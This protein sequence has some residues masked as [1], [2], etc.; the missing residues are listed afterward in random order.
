MVGKITM[1]PSAIIDQACALLAQ[2]QA[3]AIPTETVYG[4]AA[5][6]IQDRGVAA[7]YALKNRPIFNPLIIH[8][9]TLEA[10]AEVAVLTPQALDFAHHFWPG[11]LT[12]V[13]KRTAHSSISQLASGGLETVAIR[14]PAHPIMQTLMRAY[15]KP[16][17]APSANRS[18]HISPTTPDHVR[19]SFGDQTP[20]IVDGGPCV[21]GVE[22]TI[23]DMTGEVPT[24]LRPGFVTPEMIQE[25]LGV[26][27]INGL[28][29][30]LKAPGMMKRH[31][32]P[33]R[34]LRINALPSG[35][36]QEAYIGFGPTQMSCTFNLSFT[37]CLIEAA[38][39]LFSMLHQAD[40]PPFTS[41]AVAPIP[42]DGL[43]LAIND[44][45]Q[46]AAA[47]AL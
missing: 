22:S 17:A 34:P 10:A 45:L 40:R 35:D 44:R 13:L 29:G 31:Y 3:V 36:T 12:L 7:V 27:V 5:D 33:T 46:R 38:A 28:N 4:L 16:L 23:I 43:G 19:A 21:V 37:G 26:Q 8:V 6:A 41:I 20:F 2:G 32:A 11:P 24:L 25:I 1:V 30:P 15:Q 47:M 18:N 9:P 14:V 39:R 42:T